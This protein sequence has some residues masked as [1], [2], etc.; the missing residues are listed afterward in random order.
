MKASNSHVTSSIAGLS[1]IMDMSM[2]EISKENQV[3][4]VKGCIKKH[5]LSI[6]KFYQKG[7]HSHF[8]K[9]DKTMCGFIMKAYKHKSN[10]ELVAWNAE[11]SCKN[12]H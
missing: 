8:S 11:N 3:L 9:D 10:P 12:T 5:M 6:W 7:F 4:M 1:S 2:T